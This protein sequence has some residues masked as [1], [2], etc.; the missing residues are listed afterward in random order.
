MEHIIIKPE[1]R[2]KINIFCKENNINIMTLS[3]NS[4]LLESSNEDMIKIKFYITQ[5]EQKNSNN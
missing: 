1:F 2:E 4:G 3:S 5:L